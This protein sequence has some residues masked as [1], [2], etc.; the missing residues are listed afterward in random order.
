MRRS[1]NIDESRDEATP[2]HGSETG[3]DLASNWRR[4]SGRDRV[5]RLV[6]YLELHRP[7]RLLL[8][9]NRAG[10]DATTLDYIVNAQCDQIAAALSI[11]RLN[12]ASSRNR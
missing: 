4:D 10:R 12:N 9:D 5:S 7:L 11:A 6:G 1:A 2:T 3:I 8:H